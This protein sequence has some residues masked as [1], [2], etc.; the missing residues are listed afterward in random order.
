MH[1]RQHLIGVIKRLEMR[2][3]LADIFL[4]TTT[5]QRQF[6]AIVGQSEY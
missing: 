2:I 6:A 3:V 4:Q 1:I 5:D